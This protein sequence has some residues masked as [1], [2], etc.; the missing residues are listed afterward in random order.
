M[1]V[2]GLARAEC[3]ITDAD[4]V[5]RGIDERRPG[6]VVNAAA[7]TA[8]D[9]AENEPEAAHAINATGPGILAQAC[10]AA[11]IPLIHI[12]TDYV[13][14][15]TATDPIAEDAP[16]TPLGVYGKSKLAGEQ[17]VREH[18]G[19]HVILRISWVFGA[20]G[21][22]FVKTMLRL[23]KERDELSVV[24]DQQ[25]CPTAAADVADVILALATRFDEAE[26]LPWGTYHYGG[27]PA[28]TWHGF[29]EEIVS[30]ARELTDLQA[31]RVRPISTAEFPTPAPR[32]AYSVLCTDKLERTFGIKPRPWKD[33]LQLVLKELIS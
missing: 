25:G 16:E 22:N 10:A 24:S 20:R 2:S 30:R 17:L 33:S 23:S 32:P 6:L 8:V 15:G 18:C 29:A 12:S 9:T 4:A 26:G 1:H 7:Y 19:D 14:D 28:T 31:E 11:G 21:K 5:A 3:D 27:A 13:F